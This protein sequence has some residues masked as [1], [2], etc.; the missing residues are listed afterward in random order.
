MHGK[1]SLSS[2]DEVESLNTRLLDLYRSIWTGLDETVSEREAYSWPLL[3][4]ATNPYAKAERRLMIVG[5]ET[6]G[7]Y[8]HFEC[9]QFVAT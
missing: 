7:W 2:D 8:G 3:I 5:Q 1:E 9:G 4:K 6:Y